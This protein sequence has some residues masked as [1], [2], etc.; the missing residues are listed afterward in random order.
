MRAHS[1]V[2]WSSLGFLV[3]MLESTYVP[4]HPFQKMLF[5]GFHTSGLQTT[6]LQASLTYLFCR[7]F[8]F[9]FLIFL[10]LS[11]D[12]GKELKKKR[13]ATKTKLEFKVS[14]L[15]SLV[16]LK[17]GVQRGG[18]EAVKKNKL[19]SQLETCRECNGCFNGL[20]Q[21]AGLPLGTLNRGGRR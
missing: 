1:S 21:D 8:A 20:L 17:L 18:E 2:T 5:L 16:L 4:P 13:T 19:K 6:R 14:V 9:L 11:T 3:K 7:R 12:Y 10:F 15:S